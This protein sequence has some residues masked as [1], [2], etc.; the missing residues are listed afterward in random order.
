MEARTGFPLHAPAPVPETAEPTAEELA[1]LR[2]PVRDELGVFYP[3]FVKQ[4]S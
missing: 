1:L 4:Q 3:E 2:G